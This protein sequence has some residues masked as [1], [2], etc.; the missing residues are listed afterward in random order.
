M[1]GSF[2][3]KWLVALSAAYQFVI[4]PELPGVWA[5]ALGDI[6]LDA[7]D[8]A[9]RTLL[10][11]WKPDFGRKFPAPAD[12]LSLLD[13][14]ED[15]RAEDEWQA[16][17][18]Y[19]QKWVNRDTARDCPPPRLPDDIER[20]ACA[21]GGVYY[22]EA[23]SEENLKW[24]KRLFLEDLTR[25]RKVKDIAPLLPS[26]DVGKLLAKSAAR[27]SLPTAQSAPPNPDSEEKLRALLK[28][29]DPGFRATLK[30]R[31]PE[32]ATTVQEQKEKWLSAQNLERTFE[33]F[34]KQHKK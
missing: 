22:L 10:R 2:I 14:A 33:D 29:P 31:C 28:D 20:A 24:A 23:C 9:F 5:A 13:L 12:V 25:R 21:A 16:L 3:K 4:P 11:T 34:R 26:S 6:P 17:L 8:E 27:F 32:M 7:L 18:E 1:L 30:D 19:C 15:S